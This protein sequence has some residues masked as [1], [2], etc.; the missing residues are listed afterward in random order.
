MRNCIALA[1]IL[2]LG[3]LHGLSADQSMTFDWEDGVTTCLGTYG[4]NLI[5]ENSGEQAYS[6]TRS[7]KMIETPLSGTP[8]AF[9]WWVTGLT[10]GDIIDASFAVYDTTPG[11]SASGRIWGHYT[12]TDVNS[13]AG[14]AG[15]NSTYSDGLG[16]SVLSHQWTFDSSSGTRDGLVVE[17]RIYSDAT[18][19]TI[20]VDSA[21]ITVSSDVATIHNAAGNVPVELVSFEAQPKTDCVEL[22]WATASELDNLGFYVQRSNSPNGTYARISE[23]IPGQGNSNQLSTYSWQD[24]QPVR[25]VIYYMLEDVDFSGRS[26]VHGPVRVILGSTSSWGKIKAEFSE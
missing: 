12:D 10:D 26:Q 20:Y 13:N 18:D 3:M 14:S 23:L 15:G 19:S 1:A 11:A 22:S 5:V 4:G 9:I 7:L 16:W 24:L 2:S 8:Q 17:A 6:G 21:S 25:G